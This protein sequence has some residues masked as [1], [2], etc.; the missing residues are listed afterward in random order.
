M[1]VTISKGQ[2]ITIP[3]DVRDLLGLA[4]GSKI[5]LDVEDDKIILRALGE[6]L[7]AVFRETAQVKPR[8]K[9]TA[10]QMDDLNERVFR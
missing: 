1:I 10:K 7:E 4:V 3:A 9:L 2:Q 6:D 8:Y 5:E